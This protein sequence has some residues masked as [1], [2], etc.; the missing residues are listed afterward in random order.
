MAKEQSN[1]EAVDENEELRRVFPFFK[2]WNGLYTFVI[3]EL[4]VLII[5]FYLF[6]EAFA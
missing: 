4:V 5:L 3:G 2:T 1:P 6:S